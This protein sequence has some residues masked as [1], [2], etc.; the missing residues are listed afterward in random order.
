MNTYK[1]RQIIVE[2]VNIKTD[3][4]LLSVQVNF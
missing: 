3:E 4:R 2:E 1:D